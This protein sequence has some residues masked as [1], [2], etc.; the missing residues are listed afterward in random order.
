MKIVKLSEKVL[1]YMAREYRNKRKSVFEFDELQKAF[2]ECDNDLLSKSI[3]L[4]ESDN[5]VNIFIADNIPYST[6][7][8]PNAIQA[9]EEDTLI[10]KGY[11]ILKEIRALLP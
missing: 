2:P 6:E 11:S 1:K 7:L 9:V 10:K 3:Y 5:L 8:L 4:L